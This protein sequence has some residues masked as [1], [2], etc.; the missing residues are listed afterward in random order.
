MNADI[1]KVCFYEIVV[2]E[3]KERQATVFDGRL[4]FFYILRCVKAN[5]GKVFD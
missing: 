2:S 5:S 4:A 1:L 3:N